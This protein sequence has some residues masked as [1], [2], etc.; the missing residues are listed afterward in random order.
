MSKEEQRKRFLDR[1]DEP[2]KRWKFSMND[3]AERKLW[4]KYM[5]A[6]EDMIRHTSTP[7]APWFVVP[8]DHKWFT[9][10]VVAA[11]LVQELQSLDLNY[12]KI[13]GKM[14]KELRKAEKALKAE[15]S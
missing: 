14:L 11:A 7:E 2:A 10:I 3:V 8:A 9:R 1:I 12:P 15:K 13:E 6:F 5:T 4:T